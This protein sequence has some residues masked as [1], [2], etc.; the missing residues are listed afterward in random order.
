MY[1]A[2]KDGIT[3]L[4]ENIFK[5]KDLLKQIHPGGHYVAGATAIPTHCDRTAGTIPPG[6]QAAGRAE[7]ACEQPQAP[8]RSSF[9]R[10]S[11]PRYPVLLCVC[12]VVATGTGLTLA[13][14]TPRQPEETFPRATHPSA[15]RLPKA[16]PRHP[17]PAGIQTPRVYTGTR[18]AWVQ[19]AEL[20]DTVPSLE[21]ETVHRTT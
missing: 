1:W 13:G 2:V 17:T 9:L 6:A 4:N 3:C 7:G 18:A 10:R 16:L 21:L 19:S 5:K 11:P 8:R 14:Q 20:P 15:A 12:R